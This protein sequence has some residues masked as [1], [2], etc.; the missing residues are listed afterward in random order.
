M[1]R[2][3]PNVDR[4][5]V[6]VAIGC[7]AALAGCRNQPGAMPNPFLA[8]D[9]VPPPATRTLLP[10]QAQPYYPGDP[11]PVMQSGT[12]TPSP[13]IVAQSAPA[14][15]PQSGN[16]QLTWGT[17]GTSARGADAGGEPLERGLA[18]S[19]EQVVAIPADQD[20]L[21]FAL[22]SEREFTSPIT[23]A[24]MPSQPTQLAIV[25]A[26]VVPASYNSPVA[27]ATSPASN[28]SGE[29][30]PMNAVASPWRSPQIA[31]GVSLSHT[32]P[33]TPINPSFVTPST[34]DVRMRAVASPPPEPVLPSTPR[35]RWP[36]YAVPPST[37]GAGFIAQ[38]APLYVVAW[39]SRPDM[40]LQMAS[41]GPLGAP[42]NQSAINIPPV[43][44]AS[45]DGFRPRGSV[46]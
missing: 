23:P 27:S 16:G 40:T 2:A 5:I 45:G 13:T 19:N 17:A 38:P 46:R 30:S 10:G 3:H 42:S 43:A 9:R 24:A 6:V 25:D 36:G 18:Q 29:L 32:N 37:S 22:P 34:M 39:P 12:S 11:L 4:S 20:A 7:V 26:A 41:I 1:T 14:T 28:G 33:P 15:Q 21:R 44:V 35:I 31:R 8:P